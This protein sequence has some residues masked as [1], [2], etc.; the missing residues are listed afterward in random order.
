MST[1]FAT[2]WTIAHQ[3][4]LSVEFLKQEYWSQLPFPSSGDL[5]NPGI[6]PMPPALAGG[7]FT[8]EPPG[9]PP[10][11]HT[12]P[13][14]LT[15]SDFTPPPLQGHCSSQGHGPLLTSRALLSHIQHYRPPSLSWA[16][17]SQSPDMSQVSNWQKLKSQVIL[18][19]GEVGK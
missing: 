3:A 18:S 1:S 19:V 16:H 5:P 11:P 8:T 4:P 6:K 7:F 9:K 2:P 17:S 12:S 10:F 13:Y 14:S 15:Q